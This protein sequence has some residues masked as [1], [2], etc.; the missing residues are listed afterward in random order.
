MRATANQFFD[1]TGEPIERLEAFPEDLPDLP[2][3]AS[4]FAGDAE[5]GLILPASH[6]KQASAPDGREAEEDWRHFR[7]ALDCAASMAL[8]VLLL[9]VMLLVMAAIKLSDGGPV[10]FAHRRIGRGGRSFDCLKFRTMH[11]GAESGLS[12]VLA[13]HPELEREWAQ[14]Q[15]LLEDPR[16]TSIGHFL[17]NTSL[18]ELPQLLNVLHGDMTLVGPRPIVAGELERYG[19]HAETYL[20]V[21]PGLTGLWQ[22]TRD[23]GTSYRRRVATDVLYVRRR[24][25]ALDIRIAFATVPAV[26]FGSGTC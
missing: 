14:T 22:V 13:A 21:K 25:L 16:V 17:R 18:D 10:L 12:A 24:S 6:A 2:F 1:G 19:R 4:A 15:K 7:R 5:V 26:L 9:P 20:K 11:C 8:I 3:L 23:A